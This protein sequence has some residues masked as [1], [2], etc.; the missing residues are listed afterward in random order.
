MGRWFGPQAGDCSSCQ[1]TTDT[2]CCTG[3]GVPNSLDVTLPAGWSEP[4]IDPGKM[5]CEDAYADQCDDNFSSQ[6]FNLTWGGPGTWCGADNFSGH[7]AY[8]YEDALFC[9]LNSPHGNGRISIWAW[10]RCEDGTCI[11]YVEICIFV[12]GVGSSRWSYKTAPFLP[13]DCTTKIWSAA[14]YQTTIIDISDP[15]G[16][17]KP[18][19]SG[20]IL[21]IEDGG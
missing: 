14:L 1:C 8:S 20:N 16:M 15:E 3:P 13:L 17:C 4:T 10:L 19:S 9:T 18:P 2:S 7:P 6:T 5:G 21:T 11:I 12:T